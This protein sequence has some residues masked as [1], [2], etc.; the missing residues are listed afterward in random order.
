MA[1]MRGRRVTRW[2]PA[3]TTGTFTVVALLTGIVGMV[4]V[5]WAPADLGVVR[6][7]V[8]GLCAA[9]LVSAAAVVAMAPRGLRF[10]GIAH[11]AYLGTVVSTP[12]IGVALGARVVTSADLEDGGVAVAV[13]LVLP[14]AVGWYATHVEPFRL[15][16]DRVTLT[17][18]GERAGADP[19][20][21]GVIADLQTS[22]PG[23][24]EHG[25]VD[26]LLAEE[27]DLILLAG[28]M[29]QGAPA[30][31][32]AHL[33]G[34]RAL[35]GCLRA[36]H[37]VY[38]VRGDSDVDDYADRL[39]C[40]LGIRLLD[41]ESVDV[42]V[43]DR[44]LR[45]GG[46]RLR[47]ATAAAVALRRRLEDEEETGD[48]DEGTV[49]I[50]VAHRPDAVLDLTPSSRVDL[51]VAGHTHGGQIVVPGFG[52]LLTLTHVPRHVAAGGLHEI[53]D[54]PI[55]VGTGVGLERRQAPQVRLFCRPSIGVVILR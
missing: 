28:D 24:Y 3:P 22:H 39:V 30:A 19:V 44:H 37:G 6:L 51:T 43:G 10:F 50:L 29:F 5:W 14:A 8:V 45:L 34:M 32:A 53:A 38:L 15:R 26:R 49:R 7:T 11:V 25:A 54:N 35:L 47:Y 21:I 9:A 13:L 20:R 55:Y 23:P 12:L 31:F 18:R 48:G 1:G 40:G 2:L 16:V 36:P 52:P 42:W 33:D 27:P 17:L 41:D 4:A 46:N